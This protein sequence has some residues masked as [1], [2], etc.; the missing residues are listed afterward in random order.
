MSTSPTRKKIPGHPVCSHSTRTSFI[1]DDDHMDSDTDAEALLS[2]SSLHRVNDRV[3]KIQDLSSKDATQDSNKHSLIWVMLMSSTLQASVFMW[4]NY[5]ENVHSITNTGKDLTMQQMYDISEKLTVGQSD[6]IFGVN[7]INWDDSSWKHLS[8][9]GG[10]E[11]VSLSLAKVYVFFSD[12][13][14]CLGR[15]SQNPLS[16]VVWEDKLTWFKS[17]SEYRELIVSQWNSSGIFPRF[18]HIAA[19]LQSPI[20]HVEDEQTTRRCHWTDNLHVDV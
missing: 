15:M 11:V 1:F 5:L 14:L 3:Q 7:T 16:N 20:V 18:H 10:E 6:D 4:K 8:L 13:V 17:S 19:L 9:I 2:R 12:S